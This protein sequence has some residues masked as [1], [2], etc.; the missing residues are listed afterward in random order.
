MFITLHR[1][2]GGGICN[3][4]RKAVAIAARLALTLVDILVFCLPSYT[5]QPVMSPVDSTSITQNRLK[6]TDENKVKQKNGKPC[7]LESVLQLAS[8]CCVKI[9]ILILK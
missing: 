7:I 5:A 3:N 9:P 1:K 2:K 4:P 6:I 8:L